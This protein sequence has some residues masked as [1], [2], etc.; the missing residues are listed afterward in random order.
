MNQGHNPSEATSPVGVNFWW[1]VPQHVMV[2]EEDAKEAADSHGIS[3]ILPS[4]SERALVSRAVYEFQ[5]RRHKSNR[6][7]VEKVADTAE[8]VVYGVL[9]QERPEA[10]EVAFA[11]TTTVK[12]EKQSGRIH[13]AGP[14]ADEV[15]AKIRLYRGKL[16]DDDIRMFLGR[17]VR[18]AKGVAK[19]P[20]GGIYFVPAVMASII[21]SAQAFLNEI[22]TGA[23]LYVER[24]MDGPQERAIVWEA[25]ENHIGNEIEKTLQAVEN[26][27]KRI[28]AV[29][30]HEEK[31]AEMGQLMDI[32]RG[33]LGEEAK[34]EE[35]AEKMA[36]A[37]NKVTAKMAELQAARPAPKAPS[38]NRAP[39]TKVADGRRVVDVLVEVLN[40]VGSPM[41]VDAVVAEVE[42]LGIV[43][44]SNLKGA[45]NAAI[46]HEL[47]GE[48]ASRIARVKRGVYVA[49]E[50]WATS[51]VG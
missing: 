17:L 42:S 37:A 45:V 13:A 15:L 5:D 20:S 51:Q 39:R 44:S 16:T 26:I 31:L 30:N 18:E 29:Q 40:R 12:L 7:L 38:G 14:L 10:E 34:H 36:D 24:V 35:L 50:Q 9:E 48:D 3:D 28:S 27:G 25:V 22:G 4:P 41:T 19:R 23:K 21:E 11:Q 49:T 2:D 43:D 33:L 6:R 8:H 46:A 47:H 1:H 32:Y